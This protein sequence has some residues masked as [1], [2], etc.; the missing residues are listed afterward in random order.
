METE[1]V[2]I[3]SSNGRV[4]AAVDRGK[5]TAK[6]LAVL[7]PGYLDSKD[8]RHLTGLSNMLCGKGYTVVRFEPTGT[9]ESEGDISKYTTTQYLTDVRHVIDHMLKTG[10]FRHIVV[11]GHS[12]GGQVAI[13]YAARDRRVSAVVAIMPS[14]KRTVM[15]QR[16]MEWKSRGVSVSYRDQPSGVGKKKMF[17]VPVTHLED[18]GRYDVLDEV[19]KLK[20]PLVIVAGE[21]DDTCTPQS[22]KEIFE[23]ANQPKRIA[24]LRGIGHNYRLSDR[25]I[26][27]VGR[28]VLAMMGEMGAL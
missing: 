11:G 24:V 15:D 12:R 17:H 9:W 4:A 6:K 7:C 8:Y 5:G 27:V 23:C 14:S 26:G 18:H 3:K 16:Y 22:I 13:L 25:Q 1:K 20:A 28:K 21:L 2:M 10:A 19:K